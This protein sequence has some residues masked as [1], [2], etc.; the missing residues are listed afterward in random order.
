MSQPTA[1]SLDPILRLRVLA[2]A[3]PGAVVAERTL[4]APFDQVWRVVADLETMTSRYERNVLAVEVI[5]RDRDHA[6]IL[7]TIRGGRTEMMDVR[8]VPGW[9]LM[10]SPSTVVA[11]AAREVGDRTVLAHLELSRTAPSPRAA[12]SIEAHDKLT[13]ELEAIELLARTPDQPH[14]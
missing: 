13:S 5:S 14:D 2:A 7:V 12:T 1:G 4:H 6:Q 11:F 8:I 10:H 3:L 9:C